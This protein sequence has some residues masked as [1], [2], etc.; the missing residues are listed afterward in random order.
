MSTAIEPLVAGQRMTRAEF[1]DRYEAMPPGTTFEL[2]NGVVYMASPVSDRHSEK[3]GL[4]GIW[5][6]Y[7]DVLTPGV[8]VGHCGSV[9]L[10][11]R[12]EVQPD[13]MLKIDPERGGRTHREGAY[14]GG[15]PELVVEVSRSSLRIDL[16]PKLFEYER[17]GALEYLIF[18]LE[19]DDIHWHV[20]RDGRLVRMEPDADGLYRSEAFPGLWLDPVA[21]HRDDGPSL[22]ATLNGGL[23]TPEHGAFVDRL[24]TTGGRLGLD[25]IT[26]ASVNLQ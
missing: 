7:Y 9:F 24:N 3:C 6:G 16:G 10:N 23:A 18:A 8:R 2:I 21:W 4:A 5:L 26:E 14:I 17:A 11:D 22:L 13:L 15:A 25:R 20:H 19:P 1:H 12:S